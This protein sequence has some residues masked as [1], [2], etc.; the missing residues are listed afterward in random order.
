MDRDAG[1][2]IMAAVLML[3]VPPLI[4]TI[5]DAHKWVCHWEPEHRIT[6]IIYYVGWIYVAPVCWLSK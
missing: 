6:K 1:N 4:L 2:A 5:P 3:I